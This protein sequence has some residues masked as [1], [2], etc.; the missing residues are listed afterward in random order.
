MNGTMTPAERFRA[1]ASLQRVDRAPVAPMIFF[2]A[3]R[4]AGIS[5]ETLVRDGKAA[6]A[7][8]RRTFEDLGG[9]DVMP[10]PFGYDPLLYAFEVPIELKLPGVDLPPDSVWQADE[11]ENMSRAEYRTIVDRGWSRFFYR[12]LFPRIRPG[13]GGSLFGV[14]RLFA[15]VLLLSA[16]MAPAISHWKREGIPLLVGSAVAVPFEVLSA[17]RSM[18][19]FFEDL[20]DE[21]RMVIDAMEAMLPSILRDGI[22]LARLTGIPRISIGGTRGSNQFIS[23]THF[24]RFYFPFLRRMVEALSARGI[25]SVLHFDS[26]WTGNL[27]YF[28]EL[29]RA[30]CI[31][32][33]DGTTDIFKARQTLG[34]HLCLM[35]DVPAGLLAFGQPGEV[36]AYC[37]RLLDAMGTDGGFI[38][39]SGCEV[40]ANARWENVKAMVDAG[41]KRR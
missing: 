7:A 14:A 5:L 23:T 13:Y 16:R 6:F 8:I 2:F 26:D 22:A 18:P 9:W 4:H 3:A 1:S 35:G 37:D 31:L 25:V 24:E 17:C 15:K 39:G 27:H 28:R 32:Q 19:S 21:P 41:M 38:L 34:G 12:T 29:P 10:V 30:S 33:L 20:V 40:P 11:H 36:A